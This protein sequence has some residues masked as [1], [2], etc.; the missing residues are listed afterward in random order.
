MHR[1][2]VQLPAQHTGADTVRHDQVDREIFYVEFGV[3]LQALTIKRVQYRVPCSV[4]GCAGALHRRALAEFCGVATKGALVNL[5]FLGA[6]ERHAVMLQL[7]N[8]LGGLT[9]QIFHGV[10]V[11]QPVRTLDGVIH[12]PLPVIRAH[13]RQRC[14]NA[15][16]GCNCMGAGR[17]N[18]GHTGRAQ[19]LLS[20][21]QR[22]AQPRATCADH[23]DIIFMGFIVISCHTG[24]P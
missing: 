9:R 7:I 21:A 23:D 5:T 17:E 12:M 16:L 8:R 18:L 4:G 24:S 1:A 13:V 14:G 11:A 3:V 20:H 6:A 10:G 15:P 2:V 22:R 19:S